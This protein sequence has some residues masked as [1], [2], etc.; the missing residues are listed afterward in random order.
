M[1][2]GMGSP[3]CAVNDFLPVFSTGGPSNRGMRRY[4]GALCLGPGLVELSTFYQGGK[5]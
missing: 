2:A 4:S 1:L 5:G 3:R